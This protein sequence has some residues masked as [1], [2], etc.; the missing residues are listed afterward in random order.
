MEIISFV[1]ELLR[2]LKMLVK[3]IK[4]IIKT[5][6]TREKKPPESGGSLSKNINL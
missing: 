6:K 1:I 5:F 4:F 3:L 2:L